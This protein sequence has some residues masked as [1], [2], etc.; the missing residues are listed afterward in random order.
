MDFGEGKEPPIPP[1][2][3]PEDLV[4]ALGNSEDDSTENPSFGRQ[5]TD[6]QL[7]DVTIEDQ[8]FS[9]DDDDDPTEVTVNFEVDDDG[10]ERDLHLAV[11]TLPGPYDP[12][13]VDEQ[14][15]YENESNSFEGGEGGSLTVGL[16][17]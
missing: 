11:F 3:W 5:Q 4:A 6:G 7:G 12:D 16:P 8:Q 1:N 15:L 14:E 2:Y 10:E 13:E 9:F 17:P